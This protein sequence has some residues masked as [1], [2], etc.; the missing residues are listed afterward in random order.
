MVRYYDELPAP[1]EF[2][3]HNRDGSTGFFGLF[4]PADGGPPPSLSERCRQLAAL[5]KEHEHDP[6]WQDFVFMFGQVLVGMQSY[7]REQG[8][9]VP[10]PVEATVNEH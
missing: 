3:Y 7:L 10:R 6:E 1:P 9:L 4:D 5:L 2:S 8:D